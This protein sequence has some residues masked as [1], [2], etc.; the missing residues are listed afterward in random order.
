MSY[1]HYTDMVPKIQVFLFQ[2]AVQTEQVP[3]LIQ[4]LDRAAMLMVQGACK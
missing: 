4:S 2:V 1:S 3:Q